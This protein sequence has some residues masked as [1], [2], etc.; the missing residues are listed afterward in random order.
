MTICIVDTSV[1]CNILDVPGRNQQRGEALTTLERYI[2]EDLRLLLPLAAVY[3]TGNHIAHVADGNVRRSTAR[4]F[5]DQ[6]RKA[7]NGD[8]PWAPTPLPSVQA[9]LEWLDGFPDH[10]MRGVS[11]ADLSIIKTFDYQCALHRARRVFIWSYDRHLES[12]DRVS[13]AI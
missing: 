5:V 4:R 6:V 9:T 7:V 13:G 2:K 10:A 3:E 11:L 12:Y 1:F 8:A